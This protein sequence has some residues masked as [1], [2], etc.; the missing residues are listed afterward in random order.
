MPEAIRPAYQYYTCADMSRVRALGYDA[1]FT[2]LE[3]AVASYVKHYLL[4]A[5][6]YR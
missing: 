1:S 3:A 2:P 4:A 5:D 6:P